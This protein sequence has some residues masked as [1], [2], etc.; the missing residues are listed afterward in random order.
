MSLLA[1][2]R[3]VPQAEF[4][5]P[6]RARPLHTPF[7]RAVRGRAKGARPRALVTTVHVSHSAPAAP[8]YQPHNLRGAR[9][10]RAEQAH[11]PNTPHTHLRVA[12]DAV[13]IVAPA[14]PRPQVQLLQQR[15]EVRHSVGVGSL[16]GEHGGGNRA[17]RRLVGRG[18]LC[19][20]QPCTWQAAAQHPC[21]WAGA[22]WLLFP[23][24]LPPAHSQRHI[25][26]LSTLPMTSP[27]PQAGEEP[28]HL[29]PSRVCRAPLRLCPPLQLPLLGLPLR[30][31][32][33]CLS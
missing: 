27:T 6:A 4:E 9:A 17:Q 8:A 2:S 12:L 33:L 28:A 18:V 7:R 30:L 19:A 24:P 26:H 25:L 3:A 23:P 14:R 13:G 29:L 21:R 1:E 32:L 11:P 16:W 20:A 22:R 31:L 5:M 10:S 15:L